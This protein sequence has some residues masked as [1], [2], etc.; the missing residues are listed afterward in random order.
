[1]R[2]LAGRRGCW[3]ARWLIRCSSTSSW[4]SGRA[5]LHKKILSCRNISLGASSSFL[6]LPFSF[7]SKMEQMGYVSVLFISK[8]VLNFLV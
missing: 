4:C 3:P 6:H 8:Y 5:R 2:L 7:A 1:M